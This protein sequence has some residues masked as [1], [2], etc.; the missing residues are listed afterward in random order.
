MRCR[1][2]PDHVLRVG[3]TRSFNL[4]IIYGYAVTKLSVTVAMALTLPGNLHCV[5]PLVSAK[6]L[7]FI[8]YGFKD[9]KP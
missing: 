5:G 9:W 3:I 2:V 1:I 6:A 8:Q 4:P 7:I